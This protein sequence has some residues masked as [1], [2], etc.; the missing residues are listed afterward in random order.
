MSCAGAVPEIVAAFPEQFAAV[1]A[2]RDFA[3]S[4]RPSEP[5]T[6]DMSGALILGTY[7]R[8]SK[9]STLQSD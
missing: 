6:P 5:P 7:A 8:S 3:R 2:L 4:N 1:D 9:T